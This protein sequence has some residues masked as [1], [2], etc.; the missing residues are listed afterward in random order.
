VKTLKGLL[1][2]ELHFLLA[3][4]SA[5]KSKRMFEPGVFTLTPN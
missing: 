3:L 4:I 5:L 1:R 2:D